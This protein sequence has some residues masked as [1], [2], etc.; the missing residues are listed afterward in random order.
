MIMMRSCSLLQR[1]RAEKEKQQ[2]GSFMFVELHDLGPTVKPNLHLFSFLNV[3]RM[4]LQELE[5]ASH[6][7]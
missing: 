3:F 1:C 5:Q 2:L 4:T 6:D 7:L